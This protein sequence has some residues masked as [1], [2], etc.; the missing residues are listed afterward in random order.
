MFNSEKR[1]PI[2]LAECYQEEPI[3][4]SLNKWV[5]WV[6]AWGSGILIVL[7]V[8]GV[9]ATILE[10]YEAS[11]SLGS[12]LSGEEEMI[13][14][15]TVIKGLIKWTIYVFIEYCIYRV[16]VILI[17][18]LAAI[19][20]YLSIS[21]KV[22][23]YTAAKAEGHVSTATNQMRSSEAINSSILM[24]NAKKSDTWTCKN[25]GTENAK[26]NLYCTECGTYK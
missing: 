21:A 6:D 5:R 14:A 15:F 13:V 23:L 12:Y 17:S 10:A 8:V 22:D 11:N 24:R 25:C 9:F 4:S 1:V 3:T 20:E 16:I 7:I 2:N 26:H 19:V 18:S